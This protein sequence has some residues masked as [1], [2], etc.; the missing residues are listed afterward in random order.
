MQSI[1]DTASAAVRD[2]LASQPT[3]AAKVAFAWQVAA[4]PAMARA[5]RASWAD[6]TLRV[7]PRDAA[8][9]REIQRARSM[10]SA[11]LSQLLG[12]D[13]IRSIVVDED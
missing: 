9:R 4:G 11:R 1:R 7:V 6:G 3:T 10:L 12:P 8:W 5:S 13:V 2:L